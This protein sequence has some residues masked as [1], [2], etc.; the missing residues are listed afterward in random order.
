MR[1]GAGSAGIGQD[2]Q[3]VR[4]DQRDLGGAERGI[5]RKD[6]LRYMIGYDW[7]NKLSPG[8]AIYIVFNANV[9][10]WG[11][12]INNVSV[13]AL[14]LPT[15]EPITG[16]DAPGAWVITDNTP[17]VTTISYGNPNCVK[18]STIYVLFF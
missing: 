6:E 9:T 4:G 7:P 15:N 3:G 12:G 10:G 14:A 8:D 1:G 18:D 13:D 2:Q 17:P 16:E 5:V 11:I